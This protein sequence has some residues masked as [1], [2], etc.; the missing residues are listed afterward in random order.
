MRTNPPRAFHSRFYTE[1]GM[2]VVVEE[3][4][5]RWESGEQR[6]PRSKRK[7]KII[8]KLLPIIVGTRI[9]RYERGEL[10]TNNRTSSIRSVDDTR[11]TSAPGFRP[12]RRF[13]RVLKTF[14]NPPPTLRSG[15]NEKIPV[16]K[17]AFQIVV[18]RE[19]IRKNLLLI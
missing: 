6:N 17:R 10:K 18:D 3:R 2:V 9:K 19:R 12:I 15:R 16:F 7:K 13:K 5:P 8:L 4:N 11:L 1:R 14:S